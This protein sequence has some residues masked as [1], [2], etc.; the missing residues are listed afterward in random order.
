MSCRNSAEWGLPISL[1]QS[2]E[3]VRLV[4]GP[5]NETLP[6][7]IAASSAEAPDDFRRKFLRLT[8]D[9]YYQTGR[10][11]ISTTNG[12]DSVNQLTIEMHGYANDA[13]PKV[14][15]RADVP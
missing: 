15:L 7:S 14:D 13:R 4:L 2:R 10:Y 11:R 6:A 3:E 5:A 1:G 9:Y 8:I 12:L